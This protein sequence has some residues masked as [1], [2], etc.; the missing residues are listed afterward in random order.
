MSSI[1]LAV[2]V[3][4]IIFEVFVSPGIGFIF[5]G[6]GAVTVG[7]FL[8]AGWIETASY[9]FILFFLSTGIWAVC[10]WK[11]LKK[12][13]GGDESGFDDMV[14]DIAVVYD[15]PLEKGKM[16]QVKWSGA[17]MKCSL[18]EDADGSKKIEPGTEL[19]IK[20]VRKGVLIVGD[21]DS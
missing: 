18:H 7:G 3:F 19:V 1:W 14:G 9:Q 11:P 4:L 12:I 17:I 5:A 20:E 16:G 2:G 6:L 8:L 13:M 15:A 21:K 10:L